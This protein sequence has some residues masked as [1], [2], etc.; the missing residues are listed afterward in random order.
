MNLYNFYLKW[1]RSYVV[2]IDLKYKGKKKKGNLSY[3]LDKIFQAEVTPELVGKTITLSYK[4]ILNRKK[5]KYYWA[6]YKFDV[7]K[8][9]TRRVTWVY[10]EQRKNSGNIVS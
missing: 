3:R 1:D 5:N 4:Y 7:I 10:Q 2:L 9:D 8:K 6:N